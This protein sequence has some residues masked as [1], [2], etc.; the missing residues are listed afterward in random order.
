MSLHGFGCWKRL[1]NPQGR[2]T[3]L[4]TFLDDE[5][6]GL[7][8][9]YESQN[10]LG[11]SIFLNLQPSNFFSRKARELRKF[12]TEL[13][14]LG[15]VLTEFIDAFWQKY[16]KSL[17]I[18]NELL[19]EQLRNQNRAALVAI[20]GLADHSWVFFDSKNNIGRRHIQQFEQ[21]QILFGILFR[22][23]N[24]F[25]CRFAVGLVGLAS[26]LGQFFLNGRINVLTNSVVVGLVFVVASFFFGL[27]FW[28]H[29]GWLL[30]VWLR[31]HTTGTDLFRVLWVLFTRLLRASW[32]FTNLLF[33]L[34]SGRLIGQGRHKF[35]R[36]GGSAILDNENVMRHY[37]T[38]KKK[39]YF[40]DQ[41]TC[42]SHT[43]SVAMARYNRLNSRM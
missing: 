21:A 39:L 15:W 11:Y 27:C 32:D 29:N 41:K 42:F 31:L 34:F 26:I 35:L 3:R 13:L 25:I 40:C 12:L 36:T 18:E 37:R 2:I 30:L 22:L 8:L 10:L 20:D 5:L 1:K 24:L 9:T 23:L 7:A 28:L 4:S 19:L 17:T 38:K 14:E 43:P 33:Y 16:A 6:F